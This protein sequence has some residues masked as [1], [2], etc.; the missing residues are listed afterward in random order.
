LGAEDVPVKR[1]SEISNLVM[2]W[3]G[4]MVGVIAFAIAHQFGSDGTFDHCRAISP[5]PLLIVSLLAISATLGGAFASWTVFR[6]GAEASERKV[7]AAISMGSSALFVLALA[8]PII[9]ALV[10]PPCFQ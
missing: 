5:I 6:D 7:I 4:L 9:A 8:L 1:S 3:T 10:I 2:P